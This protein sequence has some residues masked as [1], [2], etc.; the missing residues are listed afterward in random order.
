MMFA[1][2]SAFLLVGIVFVRTN[3]LVPSNP[4]FAL[5]AD[6]HIYRFMASHE[7]GAFRVAPWCWRI[8]SPFVASALPGSPTRGFELVAVVALSLT[9]VGLFVIARTLGFDRLLASVGALLFLS[10][11]YAVKFNLYD[12]W[13]TEPLAFLF[14]ALALLCIVLR[15]DA[16]FAVVLVVGVLAKESVLFAVALYYGLRAERPVDVR[17]L[18]RL[19]ILA[20][21][22]AAVL[23]G[24]R[25]AIPAGNGSPTYLASLPLPIG[26]NARTV[27]A[28]DPVSLVERVVMRR[29]WISTLV[30][31]LSAF[32]VVPTGLALI[33]IRVARMTFVR[34]VPYLVLVACQLL[35]TFQTQ[36][37]VVLAFPAVILLAL[38]GARWLCDRWQQ[39]KLPLVVLAVGTFSIALAQPGEWEPP[40]VAQLAIVVLSAGA[41]L[42]YNRQTHPRQLRGQPPANHIPR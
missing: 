13:L 33:G 10:L 27:P 20:A 7:L 38:E 9:A 25:I 29:D 6:H 35:F 23:V 40:V 28:Y 2:L 22:A 11:G 42:M 4:S 3:K 14:V 31:T 17:L 34:L 1:T 21:P 24:V 41:A 12:F 5:P 8:L 19:A 26:A 36:R 15:L 16:A 32:G 30:G 39:L 37:L 18:V